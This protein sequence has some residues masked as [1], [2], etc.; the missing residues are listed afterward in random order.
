LLS[1]RLKYKLFKK[2]YAIF[3]RN[4]FSQ[5]GEDMVIDFLLQTIG[6]PVP[7]YLEL[8]VY[9]PRNGNN[10]YKFYIRGAKGV[11]VEADGSLIE[12]IKDQ[13]PNDKVLHLGVGLDEKTEAI[14]YVFDEPSISTFDKEEALSRQSQG[15]YKIV[16]EDKVPMKPI[17]RILGE[18][19]AGLPDILSIDIEGLDYDVLKSWDAE[20]FPIPIVIT[21]TCTYSQNH[22]K[23]KDERILPMMVGKGYF[24]YADTYI[25][26]IFVHKDWFQNIGG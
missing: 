8:G 22:I 18:D 13:R 9:D 4:S 19:C 3:G 10:T 17:N 16:R 24:M 5:A 14:F 25:N 15:L 20:K 26:T 6:K 11:L 7:T 23:G 21:E 12:N 2:A 1:R